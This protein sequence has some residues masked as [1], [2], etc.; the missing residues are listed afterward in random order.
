MSW[1]P[2]R[3]ALK[4]FKM[5]SDAMEKSQQPA[6]LQPNKK[7]VATYF[8]AACW[9]LS[10]YF[11]YGYLQLER[12]FL[13]LEIGIAYIT[14][15]LASFGFASCFLY[16]SVY[17]PLRGVKVDYSKWETDAPKTIQLASVCMVVSFVSWCVTLWS[18]FHMATPLILFT[19][20]VRIYF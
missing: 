5:A 7:T 17:L 2:T 10:F 1:V 6:H 14:S 16:L 20:A 12:V 15:V 8:Y 11:L 19:A 3:F 18:H 9:I 4:I 13:S